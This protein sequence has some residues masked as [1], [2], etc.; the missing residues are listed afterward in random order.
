MDLTH[1]LKTSTGIDTFN[2][3]EHYNVNYLTS[4]KGIKVLIGYNIP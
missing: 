4:T 2:C 1:I 3:Y